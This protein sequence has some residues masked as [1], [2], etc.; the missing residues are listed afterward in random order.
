[1]EAN[2]LSVTIIVAAHKA[3]PMPDDPMYLPVHVG[4]EGKLDDQGHPLDLGYVK[5]N[6]GDHISG[7]NYGFCE[8]TGLYWAWKNLDVRF[9]GLVHYR[10]Y[11]GARKRI[12]CYRELEPLLSSYS[13]FVPR[14]RRYYIE[15]LYSHYAHTH[16]AEHLD[17]TREIVKE[18]YPEYLNTY[19]KVLRQTGG[20]MFNM[21]I[22]RRDYLD[23]YCRW[24]FDIL[25]ELEKRVDS[26]SL[27]EFQAR[28]F[29][30]VSEIL[31]NV[32]LEQMIRTGRIGRKEIRE[33][34]YLFT[35]KTAWVKK[36]GAFL[37]AKFLGKK[38]E[39]SF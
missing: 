31:F 8:L 2:N 10:R 27:S 19:D 29:G 16:Y 11:F 5:D 4:A 38:Y 32:W 24:L 3:Y 33:L 1:M 26:S 37:K 15:S 6:E 7:K 18:K 14:K 22:M 13:V 23:G 39:E 12:L 20:Y 21:F 36:G 28:F 34:G 17:I 30:R 25:F 9:L 35:E